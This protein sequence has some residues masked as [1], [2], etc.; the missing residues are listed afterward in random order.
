LNASASGTG[1]TT[2]ASQR[3]RSAPRGPIEW[4][5]DLL[6]SVRFG[7]VVLAILFA[8]STLGSAGLIYPVSLKVLSAESWRHE[9]VRQWPMFEMTEFEWFHTPVF[10]AICALLGLSI[11]ITT[12]RTIKFKV[13]NYGVWMIHSG[14]ILLL[15]GSVIYFG[16][17]VEGDTPVVR[18]EVVARVGGQEVRIPALPGAGRTVGTGAEARTIRVVTVDPDWPLLTGDDAGTRVLS[19]GVV[20]ESP[21]DG[22]GPM[23]FVRQLLDGHPQ[24]TEDIIPGRGRAVKLEEFGKAI[25]DPG[26]EMALE[27][28]AEVWYW[29]KDSVAIGVR[30]HDPTGAPSP[31]SQRIVRGLPRY[32]DRVSSADAVW[33]S[34]DGAAIGAGP[35][36][37]AVPP[38]ADPD[39]LGDVELRLTGF[40][41]YAVLDTRREP[42]GTDPVPVIDLVAR[43]PSGAEVTE[44]VALTDPATIVPVFGGLV[45]VTADGPRVL[46]TESLEP[47]LEV[48]IGGAK[49]VTMS[50]DP[51]AHAGAQAPM[52]IGD[53]GW[54][55]RIAEVLRRIDVGQP[56]PVSLAI[57]ELTTPEGQTF[58]R[59]AF[60]DPAMTRDV[61]TQSDED[62]HAEGLHDREV[63]GR[64]VTTF[65]PGTSALVVIGVRPDG[66]AR[67]F[68]RGQ[69]GGFADRELKAGESVVFG[70]GASI[71]LAS[72]SQ[73]SVAAT[74]PMIIP[75]AG[76]DRDSDVERVYALVQIELRKGEWVHRAWVPFSKYSF[77]DPQM[78]AAGISRFEPA[79]VELPGGR[80]VEVLFT[81]ERRPLTNPVMLED[82]VLTA[83]VGG[84]SGDVSSIRDWTSVIRFEG[85][86]GW[87]PLMKVE[88]NEPA[89]HNG[90]RYFQA[91]WDAPR[92]G[93]D[94]MAFTGLGVGNRR[95]V[96][97]QLAGCILAV[98]GMGYAFYVKPIIK[99]RRRERA[100]RELAARAA[101][102]DANNARLASGV[103][104]A[105]G[106]T[107]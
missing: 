106:A 84:F 58:T 83:T 66:S 59:W 23:R 105:E 57:I 95:G 99:R 107:P 40:L 15:I 91:Y 76:R 77:D 71:E 96:L 43:S 49:G 97:V 65:H 53:S 22:R 46:T 42:G 25:I 9:I 32:S 35:I 55:V 24:Y 72:V 30:D 93:R 14:I 18:R 103:E 70:G 28:S 62:V 38:G 7:V 39:A 17:K 21:G 6:S 104:S 98:I 11:T 1:R 94:G 48:S 78:A 50:F 87:G 51:D 75:Q 44:H 34:A 33:P 19:V 101:R 88:T 45:E 41:R 3:I 92:D 86:D 89:S 47:K 8:Y 64:I 10:F 79:L 90:L 27:P 81:R 26:L 20:V 69:A 85:P 54:K 52:P 100:L 5:L 13:I 29:I 60:P 61:D 31:W 73:T 102:L 37:I 56:E 80:T 4:T 68:Q 63:D 16:T 36:S 82:F 74:R 2:Q 12:V 67:V